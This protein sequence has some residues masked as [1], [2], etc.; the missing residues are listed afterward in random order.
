MTKAQVWIAQGRLA[1]AAAWARGRNLSIN[2]ELSYLNEFEHLIQ[3]R[4]LVAQKQSGPAVELLKRLLQVAERGERPGSVIEILVDLALAHQAR[5]DIPAALAALARAL[6][7]AEAEGYVRIFVGRGSPIRT[8]LAEAAAADVSPVYV[9]RLRAALGESE[10]NTPIS[11]SS[12]QPLV[13]PLSDRELDVLKRLSSEM[14]GPEIAQ[15][16][17]IS[18]NTLRTHTKN[19]YSKLGVNSRRAAVSQAQELGLI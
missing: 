3:A 13:E 2:D 15:T 16:L 12:S 1:D 18:L 8:L 5:N 19:I 6:N 11:H 17:M 9:R 7:L 10:V 14:S 4:I